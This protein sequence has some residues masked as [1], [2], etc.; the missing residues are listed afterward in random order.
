MLDNLFT[1]EFGLLAL[2]NLALLVVKVIAFV[3]S[4]LHSPQAYEAANKL[5]KPAWNVILG[6]GLAVHVIG[7]P[8]PFVNLAFTIAALVY[9]VDV[10]PA[11][12]SLTRRR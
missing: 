2:L 12:R 5:T 3:N 8:I 9:L 11:L 7:I 6:I 10:R 1:L 4:L